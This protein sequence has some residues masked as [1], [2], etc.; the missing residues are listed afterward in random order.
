MEELPS[1]LPIALLIL[2]LFLSAFFSSSEAAF[3]YLDRVR[4]RHLVSIEAKGAKEIQGY[5]E[6]PGRLLSTVLLGN[7][8]FNTGA[9]SL[10]TALS[11][12]LIENEQV[13]VI[14]ATVAVTVLLLI[15][16]E[17]I[18]KTLSLIHI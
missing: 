10:G 13:G 5:A 17:I 14:A 15:F 6:K 8:A 11:L 1:Y 3:L 7:N 16:G 9:A 4:L 12:S 18:P 2:C